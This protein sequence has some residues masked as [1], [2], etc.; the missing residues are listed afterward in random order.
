M[1][2]VT[3]ADD[4]GEHSHVPEVFPGNREQE[5]YSVAAA[6]PSNEQHDGSGSVTPLLPPYVSNE[7][8]SPAGLFGDVAALLDGGL[9]DPPAPVCARRSDGAALFYGGQVNTVFG[10]PESGK[11]FLC[12][13]AVAEALS[14]GRKAVVIDLDHNGMSATV[15]RLIMLGAP[16]GALA[17]PDRFR[18]VE[19]EDAPHLLAVVAAV[20]AWRPAVV[21]VDSIGELLPVFGYSSNSPDDFTAV[22]ARV[23]KPL[24]MAGAAV[25]GIDHL[26]KGAESRTAGPT[27]TAAKKRAVGGSSIRVVVKEPFTPG[28]GGKAALTVAKDRHGGLRQHCPPPDG[29]EQY[30]GSFCLDAHDDGSTT[31]RIVAPELGDRAP[32]A[33]PADDLAQLVALDPPPASVRDVAAR[34]QWGTHRASAALSEWRCRVTDTGAQQRVT[35]PPVVAELPIQGCAPCQ[36]L[37]SRGIQSGCVDH[38]QPRKEAQ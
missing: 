32:S 33:V 13:A 23:L 12:L 10:D 4:F 22:N 18:Y 5:R 26:A 2:P 16:V 7:Q 36:R 9:P 25:L 17:D 14:Q 19:P 21:I 8:H 38:Y 27:G 28:R 29:G 35:L 31:W 24:A 37:A 6:L 11:T 1:A 15:D 20:I 34:L 3:I 30:A